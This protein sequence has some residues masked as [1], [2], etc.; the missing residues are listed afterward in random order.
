MLS[1]KFR[2]IFV[3]FELDYFSLLKLV[4]LFVF[5]HRMGRDMDYDCWSC[6]LLCAASSPDLYRINLEQ[7]FSLTDLFKYFSLV[8]DVYDKSFFV[9]LFLLLFL[10]VFISNNKEQSDEFQRLKKEC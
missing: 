6:D 9:C 1:S 5:V 10:F 8:V 7:V 3:F 2:V 4:Y